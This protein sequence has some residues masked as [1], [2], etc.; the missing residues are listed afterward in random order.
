MR[1]EHLQPDDPVLLVDDEFLVLW[2]LQDEL[3][4]LGLRNI[5]TASNLASAQ[6]LLECHPFR[7]GFLDVNL[8]AENSFPLALALQAKGVPFAFVTGYGRAGVEERFSKAPVLAKPVA[9][10]ALRSLIAVG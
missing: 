8:G 5:H 1:P 3:E 4:Q 10:Q 7:F 9:P 6:Q 2:M